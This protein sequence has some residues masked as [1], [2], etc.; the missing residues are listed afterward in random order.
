M[1]NRQN[2]T[3]EEIL[4]EK[5]IDFLPEPSLLFRFVEYIKHRLLKNIKNRRLVE[6]KRFKGVLEKD[7]FADNYY[8]PR[9]KNY[10]DVLSSIKNFNPDD[11]SS[12]KVALKKYTKLRTVIFSNQ[13]RAKA[14]FK[15]LLQ[16]CEE[17]QE[18]MNSLSSAKSAAHKPP[19]P[20]TFG[21]LKDGYEQRLSTASRP[22]LSNKSI[23]PYPG[24]D[25]IKAA[26][27][28]GKKHVYHSS[29]Y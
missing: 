9:K 8:L 25:L 3:T 12:T 11:I 2:A 29:S 19:Q 10:E 14:D 26:R 7:W 20:L 18:L 15:E 16:H 1:L 21:A 27:D 22:E 5:D 17:Y 6:L 13:K 28:N 24:V 4:K 23:K